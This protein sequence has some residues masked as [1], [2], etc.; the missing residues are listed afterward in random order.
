MR[1]L[2]MN[3]LLSP[4]LIFVVLMLVAAFGVA[5]A[6][7]NPPPDG[8]KPTQGGKPQRPNLFRLLGLSPEQLQQV[9]K[10]NQER[11]PQMD[12]A[13]QRL[14]DANHA[15]DEAI[16]ADNL[17]E[18]QFQARLKEQQAAQAEVA[19]LRFTGEL[20]IRRILTADQLTHFRDLRRQ[21]QPPPPPGPNGP[22]PQRKPL[23]RGVDDKNPAQR[24]V[25]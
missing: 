19:R 22:G 21:F 14:R 13:T 24:R 9:R 6:Q 10:L 5:A 7:D 20:Q 25:P 17:D 18:S 15:L 12:A 16:Y 11:K 2:T 4:R 1:L 23:P 8:P 3:R